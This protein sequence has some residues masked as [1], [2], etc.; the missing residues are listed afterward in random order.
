MGIKL[1]MNPPPPPPPKECK[2]ACCQMVGEMY[3]TIVSVSGCTCHTRPL[4]EC[5]MAG[6]RECQ[7][8]TGHNATMP[9][10]IPDVC[11]RKNITS[12]ASRMTQCCRCHPY[13]CLSSYY[14]VCVVRH[15]S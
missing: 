7:S 14:I 10:P 15:W 11:E 8:P 2:C 6:I 3:V 5:Q 9:Q 12:I 4:R 1:V 13:G